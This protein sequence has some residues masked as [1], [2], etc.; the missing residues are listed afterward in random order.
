MKKKEEKNQR[1]TTQNKTYL[2]TRTKFPSTN[3]NSNRSGGSQSVMRGAGGRRFLFRGAGGRG[4]LRVDGRVGG[5]KGWRIQVEETVYG[6]WVTETCYKDV[7]RGI[8]LVFKV[9][10]QD[11]EVGWMGGGGWKSGSRMWIQIQ[12][13]NPG[14]RG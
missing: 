8:I 10:K 5:W 14:K 9:R 2:A 13:S 1:N 12:I 7:K 3:M 6:M 11:E 4:S